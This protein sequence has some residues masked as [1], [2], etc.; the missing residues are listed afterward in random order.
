MGLTES[1]EPQTPQ[2]L[3]FAGLSQRKGQVFPVNQAIKDLVK[4][5]WG[6]GQKGF[7]PIP[8][9]RRYP[10]DDEDMDSWAKVPK[11]DAAVASTSRRSSLP[12]EDA[13]SLSDPMDRKSDAL[14]KKSWEACVTAFKPAISATCTSRSMLVWLE[15]LDQNIRNGVSRE[16]LRASIP[17]IKG[18]AAFISDASV[19]SLRLAARTA[20]LSN[21]ARRALWL[22]NWKGDAQSRSKLCAIP[23]QEG[24]SGSHH[25][26]EREALKNGG[27]KSSGRRAICSIN[28]PSNQ[29]KNSGN[30]I[31]PVGGRLL[32]FKNQWNK[33]TVNPWALKLISSGLTLDFIR[34]PPDSFLLTSLK[35]RLQ[36]EALEIEIKSLL[37]KRVLIDVPSSQT[38]LGFYSPLFLITKPD[39]SYRTIFNLRRLNTFI[40]PVTFKMESVRSAIKN[41]FP[42]CYMVV[43]DLKDAYYHLPIHQ[44]HQQF[45]RV[46]VVID[47]Q[48]RHLQYRAMPFGLSMAPRVFTK[49]LLEVMSFLR[50]K[51]TLVIPYLDDL[52]IV[53]KNSLQCEQRLEE[54]AFSLQTLGWIVNWEKS[55]LQPV[56]CQ[57]FLGLLLDS[58][59]QICRLPDDKK[60]SI[61]GKVSLAIKK[62]SMS[63]RNAMSLLGSLSSCIPAVKWGQFHTRQL[64]KFILQ[65]DI[66]NKGHLD[67]TI[68]LSSEVVHSLT[69]WLDW[70]NLSEG[71]PWV[72]TPTTIPVFGIYVQ[73]V[74]G[75]YVQPVFG[76]YVQPVFGIY[77]QPVFGIYVQPVFG[78]YVQPVFGIYVQPVFGIYVQPVFG[79]YVQSVFGIYVQPVFGIYVQPVFG[80]YVQPVFGIYV[81]PVFGIYV[82][83]VF[84]IYVQSVFGIYVQPV[85]GI[86]VQPVFGIYVQPVFGIYVQPVFGIYVQSVFGIYVQS[87]FNIETY[88]RF[89]WKKLCRLQAQRQQREMEPY[90]KAQR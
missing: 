54:V 45:L 41:L 29:L 15:Q 53:G 35:S 58:V 50:L 6:K 88:R 55:R 73:P 20:S 60:S 86:Y 81:Q 12:V 14:L 79:I 13:G 65:E 17:L 46:A 66:K 21:T 76:I 31:P 7:V 32:G 27:T 87:V 71:V 33:I 37:A 68:Y 80:I 49:L 10:F 74:F 52:L 48:I 23:C 77:V 44:S 63:L 2:E 51:D 82:Q 83:P 67:R 42:N 70:G 5:E 89:F 11:V 24:H 38:G 16:K 9:K 4:K 64:Q 26:A 22:K 40:R 25:L 18:A 39:G 69:W 90:D 47:G 8:C 28:V 1:K 84:G 62:R 59:D 30:P 78:I 36:Q 85:F 34:K 56:T 75:I 72:I 43:L 3:M 61:V 57:R 19:D